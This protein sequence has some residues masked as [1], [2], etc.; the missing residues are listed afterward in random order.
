LVGPRPLLSRA[1]NWPTPSC[2][3]GI[4]GLGKRGVILAAKLAARQLGQIVLAHDG[5]LWDTDL[6]STDEE[7]LAFGR[8]VRER[9]H[10]LG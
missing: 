8:F 5:G 6:I 9:V 4:R 10:R 7:W 2:S 1:W 3:F